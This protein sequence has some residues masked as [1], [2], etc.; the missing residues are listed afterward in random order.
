[1]ATYILGVQYLILIVFGGDPDWSVGGQIKMLKSMCDFI[2]T[3]EF[4]FG[5]LICGFSCF[6]QSTSTISIHRYHR[7]KRHS[8]YYDRTKHEYNSEKRL[9]TKGSCRLLQSWTYVTFLSKCHWPPFYGY[10]PSCLI[11]EKGDAHKRTKR[12]IER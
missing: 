12:T 3:R 5:L 9:Q 6:Q 10:I 2:Y 7:K 4:V 8:A 11:A 1:M